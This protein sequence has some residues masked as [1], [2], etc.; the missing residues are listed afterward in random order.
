LKYFLLVAIIFTLL[1]K[2]NPLTFINNV[3]FQWPLIIVICF[4][5]QIALAFITI[6][7]N[8]KLELIL[9]FTFVGITI[10]L[11]KNRKFSGVKWILTGSIL[12]LTALLVHGGLMPVSEDALTMTGQEVSSLGHDSRHQLMEN[13]MRFW[14]LGDWI[15]VVRYVLSPGD[16]FVGLG[17]ILFVY[18]N[19]SKIKPKGERQ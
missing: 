6:E 9:I 2:R 18:H 14:I 12:N 17:I 1:R 4:G 7:T 15:P 8:E 16:F 3:E 19:S 10:G 5:V 11:W 13:S